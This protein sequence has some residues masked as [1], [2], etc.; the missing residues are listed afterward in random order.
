MSVATI[1]QVYFYI[2][3]SKRF[4]IL[5]SGKASLSETEEITFTIAAVNSGDQI[6]TLNPALQQVPMVINFPTVYSGTGDPATIIGKDTAN[7][8]DIHFLF[9]LPA[10]EFIDLDS[11]RKCLFRH[12]KSIEV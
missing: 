4:S 9:T 3:M 1:R 2:L 10:A 11:N 8:V 12:D 6:Q 7:L 5:E